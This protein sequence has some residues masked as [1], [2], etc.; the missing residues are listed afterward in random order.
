LTFKIYSKEFVDSII[1]F[2]AL[3]RLGSS[4][5]LFSN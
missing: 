1:T 3:E 4:L 2:K 5:T